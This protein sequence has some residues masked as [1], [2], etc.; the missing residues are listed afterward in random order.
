MISDKEILN[1]NDIKY[2]TKIMKNENIT[3][4]KRMVFK[5]KIE[6]KS[7]NEIWFICYIPESVLFEKYENS[8][9]SILKFLNINNYELWEI[10]V[11]YHLIKES[12]LYEKEFLNYVPQFYGKIPIYICGKRNINSI[13]KYTELITIVRFYI[14]T[15][16]HNFFLEYLFPQ[17]LFKIYDTS[18]SENSKIKTR[19]Y[20]ITDEKIKEMRS[21]WNKKYKIIEDLI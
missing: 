19:K 1:D 12:K 15:D 18:F 9:Y 10:E 14:Y 4:I 17:T 5:E 2:I 21:Y 3:F 11:V 7:P 16:E 13:L 6:D 20:N 8:F